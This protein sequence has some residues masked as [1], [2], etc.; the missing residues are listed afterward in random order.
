MGCCDFTTEFSGGET[1][2]WLRSKPLHNDIAVLFR[3][4]IIRPGKTVRACSVRP[5]S[6]SRSRR[7]LQTEQAGYCLFA[8]CHI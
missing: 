7:V 3:L 1:M 2:A 5:N 8:V 6:T 4:L